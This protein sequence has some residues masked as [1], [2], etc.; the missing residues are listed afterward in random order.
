M[1]GSIS[2]VLYLGAREL[3]IE[4]FRKKLTVCSRDQKCGVDWEVDVDS[5][6]LGF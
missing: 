4:M 2:G 5:W 1:I 6:S 3:E